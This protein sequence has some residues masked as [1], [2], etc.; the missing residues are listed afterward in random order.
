MTTFVIDCE[1]QAVYAD[2]CR[3]TVKL[4]QHDKT[5]VGHLLTTSPHWADFRVIRFK[6]SK[7]RQKENVVI[8][9]AGDSELISRFSS[10]YGSEMPCGIKSEED[11]TIYV[12]EK[13][14]VGLVVDKYT[15][16]EKRPKWYLKKKQVWCIEST[17]LTKG[18]ITGGS[19]VEFAQG[20]L[21][22]G[23]TPTEAIKVASRLCPYT[24]SEVDEVRL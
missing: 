22:A 16:A 5:I 19:G 21:E 8:V 10:T 11:A 7:I 23:C 1:R 17:V 15:V 2:S 4:A 20:A 12:V 3:T 13:R 9:G 18:F 6:T 14:D 24:N